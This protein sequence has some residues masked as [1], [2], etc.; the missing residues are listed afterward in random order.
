MVDMAEAMVEMAQV[1]GLWLGNS[2]VV[3]GVGILHLIFLEDSEGDI[4]AAVEVSGE[5]TTDMPLAAEQHY[6]VVCLASSSFVSAAAHTRDQGD[7]A[8]TTCSRVDST[9][10]GH[11]LWHQRCRCDCVPPALCNV[12][13][14]RWGKVG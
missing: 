1:F 11:R 2:V 3:D 13:C 14:E 10:G 9:P 8:F 5:H 7:G 12:L 6:L 4:K